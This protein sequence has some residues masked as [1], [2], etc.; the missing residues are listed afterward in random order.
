[1]KNENVINWISNY[2]GI[3]LFDSIIFTIFNAKNGAYVRLYLKNQDYYISGYFAGQDGTYIA[4]T[5]SVKE[6]INDGQEISSFESI[7]QT[8][9]TICLLSEVQY[10]DVLK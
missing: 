6:A 5:N 7:K 8:N 3:S 9:Y 10:M 4:L 2:F 1:M